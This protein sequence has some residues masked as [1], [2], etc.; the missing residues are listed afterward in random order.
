MLNY[1]FGGNNEEE[2]QEEVIPDP[3]LQLS[4]VEEPDWTDNGDIVSMMYLLMRAI[5]KNLKNEYFEPGTYIDSHF[6]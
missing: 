1:F 4:D 2:K 6:K 3:D 5:T